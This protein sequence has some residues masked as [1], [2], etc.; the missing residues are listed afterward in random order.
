ML[1]PYFSDETL[2]MIAGDPERWRL[3]YRTVRFPE[4][5]RAD[6]VTLAHGLYCAAGDVTLAEPFFVDVTDGPRTLDIHIADAK[7]FVRLTV[8]R[9]DT[10]DVCWDRRFKPAATSFTCTL[11]DEID[12]FPEMDERLDKGY[13]PAVKGYVLT[14]RYADGTMETVASPHEDVKKEDI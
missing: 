12:A 4:A 5:M 7:P 2:K 14:V 11:P 8:T 1:K 10:R 3:F 9:A 6:T 13:R